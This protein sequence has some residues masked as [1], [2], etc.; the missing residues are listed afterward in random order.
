MK[1]L[2]LV[3]TVFMMIP[4]TACNFLPDLEPTTV[5]VDTTNYIEV[6]T[7]Q[8]LKDMDVNKSYQLINDIDLSGEAWVPLGD[9][10]APFQGNFNG[11]GYTISNMTITETHMGFYGLFGYLKGDI[12]DLVIEDFVIDVSDSFVINAGGLAGM[13]LGSIDHVQVKGTLDLES[14][15]F[16]VYAGLLVG[17]QHTLPQDTVVDDAYTAN[18]VKNSIAEGSIS[19]GQ[20]ALAYVGALLGKSHNTEIFNNQIIDVQIQVS[21]VNHGLVGGLIGQNFVYDFQETYQITLPSYMVYENIVDIDFN[22]SD[23]HN[24]TVGGLIG[25]NQNA[26]IQYNF[27]K[28]AITLMTSDFTIGL[29]IGEHWGLD[30]E[31]NVSILDQFV[32]TDDSQGRLADIIGQTYHHTSPSGFVVNQTSQSLMGDDADVITLSDVQGNDFYATYFIDLDE[33]WILT[34]KDIFFE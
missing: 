1:K 3:F 16:N 29:M 33:T 8:E 19:I 21:D 31:D 7:V 25:Y 24:L 17:N 30:T 6:S 22:F 34:M 10:D 5:A 13:A 28:Q 26:G 2:M 32:N 11:N 23:N 18:T 4:L 20:G 9:I 27:V 14:D 12:E 15:G